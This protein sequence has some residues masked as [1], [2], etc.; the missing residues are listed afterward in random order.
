MKKIIILIVIIL[1]VVFFYPKSYI[2]S[3]GFVSA[4]TAAD[5]NNTAPKCVGYS[6]LT[7]A[8]EMAADAPGKSLCFGWLAK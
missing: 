1:V 4:E 5:F 8:M 6:Y 2:S 7:N 3:P